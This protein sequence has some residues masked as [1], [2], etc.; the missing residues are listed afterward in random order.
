M[1]KLLSFLFL[2]VLMSSL[3]TIEVQAQTNSSFQIANRLMQ[4]QRYEDALAILQD[5][6]QSQPDVFIF[7]D[8]L[9]ECHIQL[10]N[11]D[12]GL[13]LVNNAISMGQHSGLAQVIA[14]EIYHLKGDTAK[15][16]ELWKSNLEQFARQLQLYVNTANTMVE[17]RAFDQAIEVYEQ[18]RVVFNNEQLFMGDI[19][20]VY[21]QAGKYQEAIAE[22]LK[23]I[24]I[25][26]Q[27]SNN[28]RRLLL[29]YNDPLLFDDSIAEV[30]FK[31]RELP[32]NHEAYSTFYQLQIWL[33]LENKLYRRAYASALNYEQRTSSFNYALYNVG[34]QLAE[35]NEFDLSLRA[36]NFYKNAGSGEVKWRAYE[37]KAEVY[38]RWAKYL[39]ENNLDF[40]DK[41]DSLYQ[42][43]VSTLDTMI[44][45]ANTYSRIDKVYLMKAELSLDHVHDLSE[46]KS[47]L[48]RIRQLPNMEETAEVKYVQG[49]IYLAEQEFVQ[50][51][52]AFTR[53]NKI[54]GTGDLAEKTRYFLALTDFYASDFEYANIQL[55]SL[56]RQ[57]TSYYANDALTLRLWVQ[58]GTAMDSSGAELTAFARAIEALRNGDEEIGIQYLFD[59]VESNPSSPLIDDVLVKLSEYSIFDSIPF[60]EILNTYLNGYAP[61]PLKEELLWIQARN[62]EEWGGIPIPPDGMSYQEASQCLLTSGCN[63]EVEIIPVAELYESL[64]LDY[65]QGFYAPFARKRLAQLPSS[66][67]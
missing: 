44:T 46:A 8:Q 1:N 65:P 2:F 54:A 67:S 23:L 14:G 38:A 36:F 5:L 61:S 62:A 47:A 21:M 50:A 52:I 10:K 64:I 3:L 35:N 51:R 60:S 41:S 40:S 17:R 29:R 43:A 58:E 19:P 30:E 9:V 15:A 63:T 39:D 53:S 32:L 55:K 42:Q 16:F 22:W 48:S 57:N 24:E 34:R 12:R 66:N 26:T 59:F 6:H 13:E 28:F 45:E 27:Q 4:Q 25:N 31:L 18:A 20:N 49:R 7:L 56:G 37:K 11:Y 33:L